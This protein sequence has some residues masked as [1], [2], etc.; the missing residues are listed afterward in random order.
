MD[1]DLI[2][3]PRQAAGCRL[4]LFLKDQLPDCSRK[5]VKRLLDAGR[6]RVNG[7]K[8]IIASWE[9]K[10]GDEVKVAADAEVDVDVSKFFLK[11]VYED[12]AVIVVDKDAGITCEASPLALKPSLVQ[13]INNYLRENNPEEYQPYLGLIHRLD[14]ETSGL[15][16]Y[17]KQ[18]AAN[19]LSR[20]FKNHQIERRYQTVV[21]GAVERENGVIK[22]FIEKSDQRGGGKVRVNTKGT[23]KPAVTEYRVLERYSEATLLDIIPRTGRTHQI[24]VHLAHIGHPVWADKRYGLQTPKFQRY[25]KRQALHAY[26]L[27]FKHPL[28]G[29]AMKFTSELPKDMRKL[30]DKLRLNV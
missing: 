25:I 26:M 7:R 3:V 19:K 9:L 2:T 29:K 20:Q 15:M 22:T 17:S 4:D 28:T 18:K 1:L 24:R 23:G 11:V 5:A 10:A 13:I 27:A 30:L 16:V 8:A 6:V 14:A 12:E 21:A